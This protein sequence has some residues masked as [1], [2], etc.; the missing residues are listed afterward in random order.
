MRTKRCE[1]YEV[2]DELEWKTVVDV[3]NVVDVVDVED[4][5]R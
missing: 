4:D 3:V 2:D 1:A 5:G